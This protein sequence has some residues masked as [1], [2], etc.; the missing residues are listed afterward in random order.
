ME[1][2][3]KINIV[4]KPKLLPKRGEVLEVVK[5][6]QQENAEET[7]EKFTEKPE[8][9]PLSREEAL[10]YAKS[11]GIKKMYKSKK[12]LANLERT[13]GQRLKRGARKITPGSINYD[14]SVHS[15]RLDHPNRKGRVCCADM[16]SDILGLKGKESGRDGSVSILAGRLMEANER[17]TD[18]AG[19]VFGFENYQ[20]GDAV[21]WSYRK[22]STNN[23][24]GIVR[25]Q[26]TINGQDFI[27]IQHDST[28][29]QVDIVPVNNGTKVRGLTRKLRDPE[30][31]A[32]Q[33]PED[34]RKIRDILE[35]R[36][37]NPKT[38]R[39][40]SHYGEYAD[41][42]QRKSGSI[43]YA[44]RTESL[45]KQESPELLARK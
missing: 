5:E 31:L 23:H 36:K 15:Q 28:H 39:V 32:Q 25:C 44:I 13:Y 40:R 10:A 4:T 35:Y 3:E 1:N 2:L 9:T 43:M 7:A 37:S 29:I 27:A 30:F 11:L 6:P 18:N 8:F 12:W 19:I 41:R 20:A 38:V 16:V 34:A 22:S 21:I 33:N 26:L 24:I 14:W 17:T 42:S 45:Q